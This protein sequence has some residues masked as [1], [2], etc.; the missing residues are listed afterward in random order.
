MCGILGYSGS[1]SPSLL[2][3][4]NRLQAHRG[5]DDE[6]IYVDEKM[7]IGLGHVRLSII[8]LSPHGHQPMVARGG[9]LCLVFNGEIYNFRELRDELSRSGHRFSGKSDTEVLLRMYEA[10]G[11]SMLCRLNGIFAFA[12]WDSK[13]RSLF[14]ARDAI[15]VKPLYYYVGAKGF[16]FAS[17]IKALLQLVPET[18]DLDVAALH[19]YLSFLW[20]PGVGTPLR[21]VRKVAPG[22]ALVIRDGEIARRWA[23]YELPGLRGVAADLGT[24]DALKATVDKL[25]DA[26][27]RQIVSDVPVGAFLSGGLD[28]S[29]IV[30]FAREVLPEIRCFTIESVGGQESGATHDLPYARRVA[31]H[32]GVALD[33]VRVDADRM[34]LDLAGMVAQLDEPLAD[35][36]ALNVLYISRLAKQHGIKVLLSGAGGDDIFSGYR[37]HLALNYEGYYQWL[38]R[39]VLSKLAWAS[40][41]LDQRNPRFRRLTKLLSG[42]GLADDARLVN[43]FAWAKESELLGLYSRE[44]RSQLGSTVAATPMFEFLQRVP[45]SVSSLERMLLLEQRFFLADHNL[46]YTDK[47]SMAAGVEV[48]VPFLDLDLID[49][50]A[51]IDTRIKQKGRV[52]KW[53]LKKAMEPYLPNDVIYRPK[54]GF[55]APLRKWMRGGPLQPMLD[56]VL[57]PASLRRRG[58]FDPR[59]VQDLIR[60]N[61][62][63]RVDGSYTLLSILSIELWCRAYIDS[64]PQATSRVLVE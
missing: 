37:R 15:G 63:G 3:R 33:V 38:P 2:P 42:T 30:V 58:L 17:E 61:R 56:D 28:S 4:A 14:V 53:V 62:D 36:A 45:P 46:A 16:A 35:P 9:D 21:S 26:V 27:R 50:A 55:G 40:E 32:L 7:G 24:Q 19:R 20:C 47:M 25:R 29:S 49:H 48:R 31:E 34:A 59:S 13:E 39:P 11:E 18:R 22:E 51:R 54:A 23:W 52:G 6:G 10:H 1:F 41:R 60:D 8:D 5:P 44:F 43:Y 57:S 12:I 64:V